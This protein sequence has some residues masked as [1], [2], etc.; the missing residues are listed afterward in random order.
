MIP[1]SRNELFLYLVNIMVTDYKFKQEELDLLV[2]MGK[3]AFGYEDNEI[4]A[5]LADGI[6][7]GVSR[8]FLPSTSSIS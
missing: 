4:M 1:N 6:R 7:I 2:D 5:L 3:K 8:G